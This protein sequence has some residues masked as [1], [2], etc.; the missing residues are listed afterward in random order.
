MSPAPTDRQE[1]HADP[2]VDDRLVLDPERDALRV[3]SRVEKDRRRPQTL[4]RGETLYVSVPKAGVRE[5]VLGDTNAPV[6]VD[7]R[8]RAVVVAAGVTDDA[9]GDSR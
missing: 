5:G 8:E 9:G 7:V 1:Q 2:T 3:G 4:G 6:T